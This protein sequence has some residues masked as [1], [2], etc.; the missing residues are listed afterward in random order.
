MCVSLCYELIRTDGV[1]MP[2][3]CVL[4]A[5]PAIQS[6][7]ALTDHGDL[8]TPGRTGNSWPYITPRSRRSGTGE[9]TLSII[10]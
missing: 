9:A 8:Q 1:E 5:T 7:E 2:G 3:T 10:L 4:E 6:R